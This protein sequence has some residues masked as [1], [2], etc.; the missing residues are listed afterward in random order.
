M[1]DLKVV[2]M[3]TPEFAVSILDALIQNTN[4]VMVV[5]QPDKLVGRKKILTSSPV[6]A[7]ALENG[8]EVY[9]PNKI[10]EDFERIREVNPDII[11]TCAYGQIIPLELINL[12]RLGCVNVHASLLPKYRGGAPIHRAIMEGEEETGIT[13][14]YMDAEMDSGDII[15]KRSIPIEDED[16]LDSLSLKLAALGSEILIET[17]PSLVEGTNERIA[18]DKNSATYGYVITKDDE[19]IDF[20]TTTKEVYDKI[21]GLNSRPGAY[22]IMGGKHVKVYASRKGTAKGPVSKINNVYEDGLGIGTLDGEIIITEI[23]PE[24]KNR[25]LVKDYLH[26]KDKNSLKGIDVNDRMD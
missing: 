10:R 7:R 24:G 4:V 2:F 20:H 22:F 9:T 18:Q 26:G 8:I 11:I 25:L 13:I 14:M 6:K 16:T 12:P 17:L 3:G 15:S 5:S 19:L 23:K 1:K 21:R